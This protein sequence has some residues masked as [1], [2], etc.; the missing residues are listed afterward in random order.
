MENFGTIRNAFVQWEHLSILRI[1]VN[2]FVELMD[3]VPSRVTNVIHLEIFSATIVYVNVIFQRNIGTSITKLVVRREKQQFSFLIDIS[4]QFLDSIILKR[5]QPIPIVFQHW[6][7]QRSRAFVIV[8]N[9]W[10]ITR[11]TVRMTNISIRRF[12]DAVRNENS[13]SFFFSTF[14]SVSRSTFGGICTTSKNYTCL[15]SLFCSS[16][17]CS[18]PLGTSWISANNTCTWKENNEFSWLKEKRIRS[19]IRL[20]KEKEKLHSFCSFIEKNI[21]VRRNDSSWVL[22]SIRWTIVEI[23]P[24]M[25]KRMST[26]SDVMTGIRRST[27]I[28]NSE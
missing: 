15:L 13:S 21:S 25:I 11:V 24:F 1:F 3:R 9:I 14:F 19:F 17:I 26:R 10:L 2:L 18:C 22:N 7:V 23:V 27:V 16:G 28:R 5:V 12:T 4:F 8:H 6:F 20:I